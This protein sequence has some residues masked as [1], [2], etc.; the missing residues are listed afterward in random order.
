[1]N[2]KLVALGLVVLLV[3]VGGVVFV[4]MRADKA[5]TSTTKVREEDKAKQLELKF[6]DLQANYPPNPD[7]CLATSDDTNLKIDAAD[8]EN[9]VNSVVS[10]VIDVPAGTNVDVYFK[11]YDK[12]VATGTSIYESTYGSYNFI[13]QKIPDNQNANQEKWVAS[14]F[15]ACKK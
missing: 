13:A 12:T 10:T 6:S 5:A 9:I 1:M 11:T 2:K 8:Q 3:V 14:K 7:A 4:M 15:V